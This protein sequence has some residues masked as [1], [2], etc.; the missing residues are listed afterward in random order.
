[1]ALETTFK[2]TEAKLRPKSNRVFHVL[3][4]AAGRNAVR[5]CVTPEPEIIVVASG[6]SPPPPVTKAERKRA[7]AAFLADLDRPDRPT[8][9]IQGDPS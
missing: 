5:V 7:I 3:A 9:T 6:G 4:V 8:P 1:M 2:R